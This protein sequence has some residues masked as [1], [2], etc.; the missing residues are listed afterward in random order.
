VNCLQ[1]VVAG[2]TAGSPVDPERLWTNRSPREIATELCEQGHPISANTVSRLLREPLGLSHRALAKTLPTAA[3]EDRAG[4]FDRML[5]WREE[6]LRKG[7]AVLSIDTKKKEWL[8]EYHR[9][10]KAWCAQPGR[11]WDHDFT[12]LAT[13]KII[14]YGVYDLARQE[15]LVML[16]EGADTGELAVAAIR[17]WWHRLGKWSYDR[18]DP[19]LLIADCGGSNGYRV[20]LFRERLSWLA[21]QL[22]L[23]FRVS[24]VPPYC[25][26]YNPIDHRLFCHL[27][28]SLSGLLLRSVEVIRDAFARTTTSTG[29]KVVVEV[30]RHVFQAKI[31]PHFEFAQHEPTQRDQQ[32][33]AYNY[34]I[35]PA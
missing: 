24:H 33:P 11:A 8:G 26:K 31:K 20:P 12:S 34:V 23:T 15:A 19:I 16:A 5:H 28:R 7:W 18:R 1:E 4:Q 3:S 25:S 32:L 29:L 17:R 21:N 35:A 22:G 14:P 30:A 2:H 9:P 27:T 10:G 13:G 6:F